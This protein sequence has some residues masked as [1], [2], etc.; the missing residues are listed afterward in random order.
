MSDV[1]F[2]VVFASVAGIMVY[3]SLNDLLPSSREYGKQSY[4]THGMIA[5]MIVMAL[6]LLLI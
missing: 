4:V 1:F 5:G 3:I 6:S 2:G